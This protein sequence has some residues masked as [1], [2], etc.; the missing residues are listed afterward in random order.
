MCGHAGNDM[1]AD[2]CCDA[3]PGRA[4]E[5]SRW[6]TC[7]LMAAMPSTAERPPRR[8]LPLLL[9]MLFLGLREKGAC[10]CALALHARRELEEHT[11]GL[12]VTANLYRE[13]ASYTVLCEVGFVTI[14][15]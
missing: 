8:I 13:R 5:M 4:T 3:A 1:A 2:P 9:L 6:Q 10:K 15:P 7:H 12:E 14:N 11:L